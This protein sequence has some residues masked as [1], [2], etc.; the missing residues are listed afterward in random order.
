MTG[1]A[2]FTLFHL[3]HGY[4]FTT[5]IGEELGMTVSAAVDLSVEFMAEVAGDCT[6]LVFEDDMSRFKSGVAFLTVAGGGEG[7]FTVMADT[8][9]LAL[10]YLCHCCLAGT[11]AVIKL[12]CV[13]VI[14]G[15]QL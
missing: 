5:T 8:A 15:V 2:G 1:T 6:T 13:A 11:F 7:F 14:A 4:I 10:V 9:G 12:L 3:F